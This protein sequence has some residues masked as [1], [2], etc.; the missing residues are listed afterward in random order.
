VNICNW[1]FDFQNRSGDTA[2]STSVGNTH[3]SCD[4]VNISRVQT[5]TVKVKQGLECGRLYVNGYFRGEQCHA[6]F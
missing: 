4:I 6:V 5:S 2:Y 3:G 1:R